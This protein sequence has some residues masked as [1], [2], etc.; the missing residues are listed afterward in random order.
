LASAIV[1]ATVGLAS[2]GVGQKTRTHI[3]EVKLGSRVA[4]LPSDDW[5]DPACGTNGGPRGLLI[6]EFANFAR[7]PREA[8][9]G[10]HEIWFSYDDEAEL[11]ARAMHN[12]YLL[13]I[14]RANVI[15]NVPVILSLLVDDGGLVQGYRI[16]SDTR[17]PP[18][19]RMHAHAAVR[20][21]MGLA[22]ADESSCVNNPPA[23]GE[24]PF[25]GVLIKQ[26]CRQVVDGRRVTIEARAFL[27][28]GQYLYDPVT[29]APNPNAFES[30]AKLEIVNAAALRDR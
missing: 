1:V 26:V 21:F 7:C 15:F 24:R 6:E 17:A 23:E 20:P 8:E 9:T 29:G 27:K 28:P 4:E 10:L 25:E 18:A 5:V 2:T 22:R 30:Y 12:E 3:W 19:I 14:S 13:A 11:V 16:I